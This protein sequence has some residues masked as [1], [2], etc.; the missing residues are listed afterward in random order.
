S[1]PGSFNLQLDGVT[2]AT[3]GNGTTTGALSLSPGTY[4][5]GETGAGS[6]ATDLTKYTSVT[7]C[8]DAHGNAVGSG[9]TGAQV[10]LDSND[11]ITC[12]IT[13]SRNQASLELKK[14]LLPATDPGRFN[15]NIDGG[16]NEA[17]NVG[18]GGTTN[19]ISVAPGSHTIAET[20][21]GTTS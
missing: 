1:D 19:P 18:D 12:T 16:A 4:A 14:R 8:I 5:V 9:T 17:T 10:I 15:L 6:P 13:Y 20:G 7:A 21:A 2:K 3:G 11:Q